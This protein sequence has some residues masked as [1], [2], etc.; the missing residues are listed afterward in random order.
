VIVD[1]EPLAV[2]AVRR[3]LSAHPEVTVVGTADTLEA[4]VAVIAAGRPDVVFLDVELGAGNG[5]DVLARLSP[6]PFVVFVTAHPQHA[7]D[8]F[9]VAAVDYLLK[10]ILPERME[11]ALA[12][13]ARQVAAVRGDALRPTLE[14]REPRRTVFADPADIAALCAD[15]DFTRVLLAGQPSLLILRTLGQFEELLP[16]PPFQRLGRSVILN[17]DRVRRLQAR[18]RNLAHVVLDGL[19]EPLALGRVAV[20]RLRAALAGRATSSATL[21][22][23]GASD[24]GG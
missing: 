22:G 16:T 19:D 2:R 4:A 13:V 11:A 20:S 21:P 3:L 9:A 6:P 8:A 17:L 7:V 5:F 10:P 14:L 15:G 12:R 23:E 18:D 1:D 24:P